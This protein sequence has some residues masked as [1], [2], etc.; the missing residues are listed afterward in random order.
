ME[1]EYSH[2]IDMTGVSP[3]LVKLQLDRMLAS[4]E[5]L[6]SKR[7]SQMLRFVVEQT[8]NGQSD[9]IK[10]YTIGVE[11]MGLGEA[12][13]PG[14]NPTVRIHA[15]KL[16]RA[17][18]RYYHEY[19][20][21][22]PVRIVI[23][24]GGYTPVFRLNHA[25]PKD[26]ESAS[27]RRRSTTTTR[28]PKVPVTSGPSIAILPMEY[29]GNESDYDFIAGGI[30]E[31]IVIALTR[32]QEF[33]VVGPL[34]RDILRRKHLGPRAIGQEYNVR[35]LL[36]G[37]IRLLG[38]TLRLT[39][40]LTD[41]LTG[42]KLW[43]QTHDHDMDRTSFDQVEH[44]IVGQIVTTIADNF[45]V[46]PRTM[47]KEVL[48]HHDD[49]LSDYAAILR[50]HH[51]VKV[52]TEQSLT[53]AINAM[54]RVIQKDPD[55]DL[56]LALLGDLISTPFWLGY[57]D[58]QYDLGR[59]AE[60]GKRALALNPN[61]QPAHL[62]MAINHYLRSQKALCL[63]EIDRALKLNP[64]NANYLAN[65]ALFLMGLGQWEEG[66]ALIVKAMGRNP[67]HPGW[68]HIVPFLYHY[69]RGEFETALVDANG[70]NT[71]DYFW[72]P[73]IRAAVLGK[74]GLQTEAKKVGSELLAL[75]PDF[76]TRGRS[77]VQRMVYQKELTEMLLDGL[78]KAGV[79]TQSERR[80]I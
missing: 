3:D 13:D 45:G 39:S 76:K 73:L 5:L 34:N 14:T 70:F 80:L 15:Q 42:R 74:L 35:F 77:L 63:K 16:R 54:E 55:H 79:E 7:M 65:S 25:N 66:V 41:T 18:D 4:P 12:F 1:F 67:H 50:F 37:T 38:R 52:L 17:I 31:E 47:A 36:D 53:E 30:T 33:F 64:N 75:V 56:A 43:G 46:I 62:T 40:K 26:A 10:Q 48:S 58:S 32:F 22:D 49:K 27:E 51:H 68:Y 57:T 71:P 6:S 59:A 21:D 61:S 72:D 28:G 11:A 2:G 20:M 29:L 60:L 44:E 8:L 78:N 23:P 24:K 69:Y 9:R 19:G